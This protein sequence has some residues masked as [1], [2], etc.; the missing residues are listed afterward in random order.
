MRNI[1]EVEKLLDELDSHT[2]DDLE[3]QDLEFKQWNERSMRDSLGIV[4]EAAICMANGEGGTVV[5]GVAD[6]VIGR[7]QAILG[8]PDKVDV[9]LLRIAV[10]D[11]TDPKIT[12]FFEE[13]RVPEGT[14]R[15]LV[16]QVRGGLQPYT[17]TSGTGTVR[18]GKNCKPLTGS[19]R[20]KIAIE[21]GET[22]FTAQ[23]VEGDPAHMLSP[24]AMERIRDWARKEKAPTEL[25]G[26]SDAD[27][28]ASLRLTRDGKLTRAGMLIAG[29]SQ[30]ICDS[31]P[32]YVWTYLKMTGDD[33][34]TNR[35]DGRDA[36]PIALLKLEELIDRDNPITTVKHGLFHFEYRTYPLIALREALLNAFCHA[37]YR[38]NSPILVKHYADRIE[39]SNPGGFIGGVSSLNILHH[40]PVSRNP[41]LVDALLNLRLVNRSNLG[42]G[43]MF[44]GLLIEGKEP[45]NIEEM[46]NS[47]RL[48]FL[49]QEFS[50]AFRSFYEQEDRRQATLR[51]DELI[52]LRYLLSHS[53][54]DTATAAVRCQRS[55][56]EVFDLLCRMEQKGYVERGGTGR[57]T[58][59]V[60]PPQLHKEL[61][62]SGHSE[63]DRRIAWDMAKTR[64]LSIL[65]DRRKR[66]EKGL[67]NQEIR[68]ITH[69]D[70]W[71][72]RRLVGQ[73]M[74]E[75]PAIQKTGDRRWTRY[76][77][78]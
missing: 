55:E 24:T 26:L 37:D 21:T 25:T 61:G 74:K 41:L 13:L 22:D 69:Y 10:Y 34:Y 36:M 44:Q 19:M 17:D 30:A 52:V 49:R 46:E 56:S 66:G 12:P 73:L 67:S 33:L 71:Q 9:N 48:T 42:I 3:G 72:V 15:L 7:Q 50:V 63:K 40:P 5:F 62:G 70:R 64:I 8:V 68:Q 77:I 59:W 43:R 18:V 31:F 51:V 60:M 53:E 23:T 65:A 78:S 20:K 47:V 14:G 29:K 16:M 45:P 6:K 57:G 35:S 28:I 11:K 4:V 58:Y 39:M 38:I 1:T 76:D 75:N 54:M 27:L 32:G 2:A